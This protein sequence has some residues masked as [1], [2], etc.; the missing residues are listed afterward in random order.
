MPLDYK[1]DF[2]LK[3]FSSKNK[4]RFLIIGDSHAFDFYK[5]LESNTKLNNENEFKYLEHEIHN[6]FKN[7]KEIERQAIFKE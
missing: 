7:I 3:S 2:E 1:K 4:R 6:Y 5:I